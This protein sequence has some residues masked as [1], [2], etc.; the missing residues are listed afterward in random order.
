MGRLST[1]ST[2]SGT[3]VRVSVAETGAA[4]AAHSSMKDRGR[5]NK[6]LWDLDFKVHYELDY[7]PHRPWRVL[8][9]GKGDWMLYGPNARVRS[10][11]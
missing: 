9:S 5:H 10:W 6:S 7:K 1:G 11:T 8:L 2:N 3:K 4:G